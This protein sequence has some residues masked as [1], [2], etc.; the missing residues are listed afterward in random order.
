MS[1]SDPIWGLAT[2]L[3]SRPAEAKLEDGVQAGESGV[4][5]HE[6]ATPDER[7]DPL[8]D[9]TCL[10]SGR[11]CVWKRFCHGANLG[12]RRWSFGTRVTSPRHLMATG[13][14]LPPGFTRLPHSVSLSLS[15]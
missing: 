13:E 10:A 11:R 6:R 7:A 8:R 2:A 14:S 12:G 4:G 15:T 9:D 3:T 5:A 1:K